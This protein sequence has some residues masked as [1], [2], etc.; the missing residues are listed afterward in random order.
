MKYIRV[1]E[2]TKTIM[3]GFVKI[4][5]TFIKLSVC[6][7]VCPSVRPSIYPSIHPSIY[8]SIRPSVR[9]SIH[10][11]I[12]DEKNNK[13]SAS[14]RRIFASRVCHCLPIPKIIEK[15]QTLMYKTKLHAKSLV[16]D[17][18]CHIEPLQLSVNNKF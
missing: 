11:S 4:C 16:R 12:Y 2:V 3:T 10:P 6:L 5:F 15:N 9:P 18:I 7:S 13:S 8:P 14:A 17:P 1:R